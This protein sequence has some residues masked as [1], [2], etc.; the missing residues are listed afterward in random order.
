[1]NQVAT[2]QQWQYETFA[3]ASVLGL[4]SAAIYVTDALGTITYFNEPA[5]ELWGLRPVIGETKWCGSWRLFWPNREPLSLDQCPMAICLAEKR[6]IE[7]VEIIVQRPDG[8]EKHVVVNPRPFVDGDG[9]LRGAV[10]T[11]IDVSATRQAER[12]Q[13]LSDEFN[14]L[15]L[16]NSQDCMKVLDLNGSIR[17]I[18]ESGSRSLEIDNPEEAVGL[19]Y[20][21]FWKGDELKVARA[22]VR[23]AVETGV[24]R[25]SA[26]YRDSSG[27]L[28]TWDEIIS[29][30]NDDIGNP[31]GFIV[32][33]RDITQIRQAELAMNLRLRQQ[34]ALAEI[35]ASA[36][37]NESFQ[38][39]LQKGVEL[40]AE[41]LDC[42]LAKVLVLADHA[43]HLSLRAGI[44]WKE[45]LVGQ[46]TVGIER[47]SQ[48]G[49]TLQSSTPIIVK[50]LL[51][52]TRFFGPRL[53]HD[54]AVRSG[55]SVTV[56]GDQQR[57]FGVLGVHTT[58]LREF[59]QSEVD[60]LCAVANIFAARARQEESSRWRLMLLRE[61]AHRSGN[62]LQLASS[63]F[64]QTF[65]YTPDLK[66]AQ[67]VYTQR[68]MAMGR[69]NSIVA[70][71]GWGKTSL[72]AIADEAFEP[73]MHM[74][75]LSGR[76]ILLP[77]DLC[78][79]I[80]LIWHEL[81]TNSSKYGSFSKNSGEVEISWSIKSDENSAQRLVLTWEDKSPF[82]LLKTQGTGFG[83]KLL[84]QIVEKKYSGKIETHCV[85]NY[86]CVI[87]LLLNTEIS[88]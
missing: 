51:T 44:G 13:K 21:D 24:G 22:A 12:S 35:G 3:P 85:P 34:K 52:E 1:M 4:T 54:H 31:S 80:G 50:D 11:L 64:L 58:L 28:S 87:E 61:M 81:S 68:L 15:I 47:E 20:F 30:F 78:F 60:F 73:F 76:D 16:A 77:A 70:K 8:V 7:N 32:V 33:S 26:D 9:V 27:R 38:E 84:S 62:L 5:V 23:S 71:G 65:R 46:A 48:A 79:D 18:N 45:G 40:L 29:V 57:P 69:A 53:L 59:N 19:S 6:V 14:R 42:P 43:D 75:K 63:I 41:A 37:S 66:L 36:L 25:F 67:A 49:F 10:N 2:A 39:V 74:I 86:R 17:S 56:Q 83:T 88:V 55:M 72:R 82:L